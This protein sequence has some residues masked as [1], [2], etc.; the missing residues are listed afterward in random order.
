MSLYHRSK[1]AGK[2]PLKAK[3]WLEGDTQQSF[4]R[5]GPAPKGKPLLFH[6]P[7]FQQKSY[8]FCIPAIN[9]WYSFHIPTLELCIPYNCYKCTFFKKI[10]M[11]HKTRTFY[12]QPLNASVSSCVSPFGPFYRPKWKISLPFHKFQQVKSLPFHK[13][14][15]PEAWKRYHFRAQPP[16][17][18]HNRAYPISHVFGKECNFAKW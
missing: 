13:P 15:K 14:L 8:P 5:G 1:S 16:P 12:S 10:W 11:N 9:N 6:I 17:V 7:F 18:G 2:F 3:E 4:I